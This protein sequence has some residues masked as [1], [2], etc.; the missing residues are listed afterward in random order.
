MI[1]RPP[2]S[3]LFPYTTLFRSG[4]RSARTIYHLRSP[5]TVEPQR[6]TSCGSHGLDLHSPHA[7]RKGPARGCRAVRTAGPL[8]LRHDAAADG[9][10]VSRGRVTD[11]LTD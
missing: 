6:A 9:E 4:R 7:V 8:F 2:R 5:R 3:T 10:P 1:R 11:R